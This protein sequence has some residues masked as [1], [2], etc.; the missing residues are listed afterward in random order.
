MM[1]KVTELCK[2]VEKKD[3][4]EDAKRERIGGDGRA[5]H[6]LNFAFNF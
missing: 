1:Q 5:R 6:C 2:K 3:G 4:N